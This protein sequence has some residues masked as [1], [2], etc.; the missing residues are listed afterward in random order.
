[1]KIHEYQAKEL[2]RAHG[3][4]TPR[5]IVCRARE[6]VG[7]AHDELGGSLSVVKAQIH[8]GGRGKGGGVQLSRSR[9]AAEEHAGTMLGKPLITHQTGPLGRVVSKILVEEGLDIDREYYV[10]LAVDR[11]RE[12]PVL[13][14]SAEGGVE[15]EQVPHDKL[16]K[17]PVDINSGLRPYQARAVAYGLGLTGD[18]AKEGARIVQALARLFIDLDC[19]LA[20]INP[21]VLLKNGH[22]VA[23]D[24]KINFDDNALFRH[25]DLLELRDPEEEDPAEARAAQ[26]DLSYVKLGGSIG[27]MVNGAGLAMGTMDIIQHAGGEPANFLDVGGDAS[28]ER[29]TE[30]F[31]IITEDRNVRAIMVNIFGGIVKVDLIAEGI[32]AAVQTVGLQVPLVVRLEGTNVERGRKLLKESGLAITSASD[33]ADAAQKAVGAAG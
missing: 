33:M 28:V 9:A 25:K 16:I 6:E 11:V 2:F 22:V 5:G 26:H 20:E 4:P 30:A 29:V 23:L 18:A 17:E 13:I 21:L 3:I 32:L 27:C 19:S 12:C 15:I 14:A 7:R 8:A 31:K 1:M 10:A 24:A